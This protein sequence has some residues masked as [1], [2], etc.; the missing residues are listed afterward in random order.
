MNKIT[1]I[2]PVHYFND[3]VSKYLAAAFE[4]LKTVLGKDSCEIIIGGTEKSVKEAV[5]IANNT[6]PSCEITEVVDE[7]INPFHLINKC[8]YSCT[9]PY[10]SVLEFDDE[11]KPTWVKN[12]NKYSKE[13]DDASVYMPIVELRDV[14][15]ENSFAGYVNEIAWASSFAEKYG[16]IDNEGLEAYMDYNVTGAIIKTED[17]ISVGGLKPSFG[18]VAWYEFLLRLAKN[19]KAIY[20][21]PKIG[22]IHSV[23]RVGSYM[24]SVQNSE[25]SK[26]IPKLIELAKTECAYKEERE[27]DFNSQDNENKEGV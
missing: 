20:V 24:V 8:V 2:I 9:T 12:F 5:V 16:Y 6:L 22:Y 19:E 7:N 1:Y 25:E 21:I 11:Y 14:N 26:L 15:K 27:L 13:N 4:S 18:L 17:F 3:D 10:F 23:G